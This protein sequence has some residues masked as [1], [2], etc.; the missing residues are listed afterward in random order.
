MTSRPK[1]DRHSHILPGVDDGFRNTEQ[2][3]A[4]LQRMSGEGWRNFVLTPHIN[5]ELF[6]ATDEALVKDAY[7]A[8]KAAIPKEWDIKTS[9]AAEYMC[10]EGF[11]RRIAENP[12]TLLCNDEGCCLIEMSYYYRSNN[13]EDAIFELGQAGITPVISHPERYPYMVD[14]IKDIEHW[15]DMGARLQLNW[16]SLSGVYGPESCQIIKTLLTSGLYSY[17]VSDLHSLH[18]LDHILDIRVKSKY[19]PFLEKIIGE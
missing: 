10:G 1:T 12:E 17:V 4:A 8:F 15:C 18:Q 13:F 19:M 5:K 6:P 11:E 9:L 16:M 14:R 3:L 7:F 2:S